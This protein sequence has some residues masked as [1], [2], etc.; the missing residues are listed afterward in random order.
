MQCP[1]C[2]TN[3]YGHINKCNICGYIFF[4]EEQEKEQKN[5]VHNGILNPKDFDNYTKNLNLYKKKNKEPNYAIAII[6]ILMILIF[7]ILLGLFKF[8]NT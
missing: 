6:A 5:S 3:I 2:G 4:N 7:I 1:K 8:L